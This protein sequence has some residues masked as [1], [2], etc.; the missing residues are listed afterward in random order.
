MRDK[1]FSLIIAIVVIAVGVYAITRRLNHKKVV[2]PAIK[3][4]MVDAAVKKEPGAAV[5]SSQCGSSSCT[6]Y[7]RKGA[8]HTC[9][10]WMAT[11]DENGGV[12][13][14]GVGKKAC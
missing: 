10:G 8:S 14:V 11:I 3:S 2:A 5:M 13:L 4:A 1:L 9:D 7:L 6:I 12:A